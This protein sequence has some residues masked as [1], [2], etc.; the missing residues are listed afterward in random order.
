MSLI[1]NQCLTA[2]SPDFAADLKEAAT[3]GFEGVELLFETC[4]T[5]LA[6]GSGLRSYAKLVKDLGLKVQAVDSIPW[7][8][9]QC[10][11]EEAQWAV[12]D[13]LNLLGELF[14]NFRVTLCAVDPY[15]A[16]NEDELSLYPEGSIKEQLCKALSG[17]TR[18]F[19]YIGFGLC[20]DADPLSLVRSISFAREILCEC[21]NSKLSLILDTGRI[22]TES[23][24]ELEGLSGNEISLV[25]LGD[26]EGFN[27]DFVRGLT[28][29]GYK[30]PYSI[31]S[32][33]CGSGD[34]AEIIKEGFELLS[35]SVGMCAC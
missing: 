19:S 30:G 31:S 6:S 5:V 13:R 3:C 26:D 27:R 4:S 32:T 23:L 29:I 21:Q 10:G 20:P 28:K 18:D 24:S 1:F 25:R 34:N 2:R 9:E 35:K 7:I 14:K 22:D 15:F 16:E 8:P 17:F 11:A 12:Y 33:L